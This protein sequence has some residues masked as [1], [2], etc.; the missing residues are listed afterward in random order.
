MNAAS[1]IVP[2]AAQVVTDVAV[3]PI[4]LSDAKLHLRITHTADDAWVTSA[5]GRAREMAEH[6]CERSF[7]PK[8]LR[9]V[10]PYWS[11]AIELPNGP[12][13]AVSHVKYLDQSDAEQTL[14]SQLYYLDT[15]SSLA[16]LRRMPSV[17]YPLLSEREDAVRVQ[18]TAGTW[19]A[20]PRTAIHYM[21]LLIGSMN[22]N[23]EADV[24]RAAQRIEF[25]DRLLDPYRVSRVS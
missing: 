15:K 22:E 21:L 5:I 4:T 2:I 9:I 11:A 24:E 1:G 19:V 17:T 14:S 23:R 20:P 13:N 16:V 8:T 25:A 3:E 18:Y 6:I 7:A 10:L 12:V